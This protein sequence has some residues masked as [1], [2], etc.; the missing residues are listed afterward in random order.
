MEMKKLKIGLGLM[1]MIAFTSCKKYEEGPN[2]SLRTKTA[3][4]IGTYGITSVMV[5]GALIDAN[6][7]YMNQ[8]INIEKDGTGSS[9]LTF[10]NGGADINYTIPWEWEFGEEKTSWLM[11]QKELDDQGN[12]FEEWGEWIPYTITRLT[13]QDFWYELRNGN[14]TYISVKLIKQ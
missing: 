13:N 11:R 10:N 14:E 8:V 12:P 1:V 5:D 7:P 4:I 9:I 2:L 6:D 3:R